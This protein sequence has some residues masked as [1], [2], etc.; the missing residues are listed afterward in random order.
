MKIGKLPNSLLNKIVLD[1]INKYSID[2]EEVLVKPSI[3]EDCSAL[4]IGD[5][6]CL[7]STDPITGAVADIGKLAVH[8]N[9]N[10]IAAGGGEPIGIMVTA[11]LPPTITE[12]EIQKIITDVYTQAKEVNMCVL[13]GHTE[14]TDAVVKPVLSCTVIGKSKR[15]IASSGAK[16]GDDLVMTK[17]AGL[18][19]TS[20]FASDKIE[21]LKNISEDT[22]KEA[23]DLSNLLSVVKEGKI[24][25]QMGANAMHDVTEGGILGACWEV[26]TCSGLGVE[27]Y[28]DKIPVLDCTKQICSELGVNPLRLISS[29]SMVIAI[30]NGEE[31]VAE[32]AKNGI[33]ATVIGK[34]TNDGLYIVNKGEKQALEEP[35][36]DELYKV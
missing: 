13:G 24:A 14:I 8:I 26:A 4:T 5:N 22:L 7:L 31:L 11:L 34:F 27:V 1:P 28:A 15:L 3:G 19:G 2:R 23:R 35:D 18:E 10:D 20:I 33:N 29:G 36:V 6:I 32:L 17:Y 30:E 12:E 9:S 21:K 16:S 25:S